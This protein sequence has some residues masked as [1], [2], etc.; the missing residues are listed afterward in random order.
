[1]GGHTGGPLRVVFAT[2]SFL[3]LYSEVHH[4][5][6]TDQRAAQPEARVLPALRPR[7]LAAQPD[8]RPACSMLGAARALTGRAW[9]LAA[10]APTPGQHLAVSTGRAG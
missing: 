7:A 10:G 4:V 3:H 1:M 6:Q 9:E 8:P 5:Y 2:E